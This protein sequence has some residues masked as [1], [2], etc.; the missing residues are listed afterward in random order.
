MK[1]KFGLDPEK[2]LHLDDGVRSQYSQA[3]AR[4]E[5][6][7]TEWT[8][9]FEKYSAAFPS[10]HA[11]LVRRFSGAVPEDVLANLPTFS[12]DEGVKATR[13]HSQTLLNYLTP[14]LPDVIGMCR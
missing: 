12:P 14:L 13:Q 1:K 9:L 8:A 3:A 5:A 2:K 6:A 11:Q 10:E 7:H 4:G